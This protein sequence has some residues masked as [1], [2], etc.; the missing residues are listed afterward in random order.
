VATVSIL[1]LVALLPRIPHAFAQTT[2]ITDVSYPKTALYDIDTQR[3][4]PQLVLNATVTYADAKPGYYLAVGV[5]DLDDGNIVDGLG[6]SSPQPCSSTTEVAGC[7]VLCTNPQG[8]ERMQFSLNHPKR[9]WNLAL[10]AAILDD[11]HNPLPN[12]FSDYTFTITVQTALTLDVNVPDHVPVSV[13]GI[14]GSGSI[15][16]VLA[17][18]KH[19]LS[20]PKLVQ[21]NNVTRLTFSSWSDGSTDTNRSVELNH[22]I[23]LNADYITQYRLQVIT[24]VPVSGAGWYDE[25]SNVT[26][27]LQSTSAPLGGVLG[28][29]GAKWIFESWAE[30]DQTISNSTTLLVTMN[31]PRILRVAWRPDYRS[32]L[33]SSALITAVVV[34]I[35]YVVS[36]KSDTRK[37]R[38]Q[39]TSPRRKLRVRHAFFIPL[40]A[41]SIILSRS[42]AIWS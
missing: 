2:T 13:D 38:K 12:S 3:A 8:S 28:I 23:T 18:G 24:P 16:L 34:F 42:S 22:D 32:P 9:V 14:N 5:F 39:G 20:V 21:I 40:R 33:T 41:S 27:S 29:L 19:S 1:I 36:T 17:A 37:R 7:L 25:A 30:D 15:L 26:L 10:V 6:S 31:S 4:N 11:A 35:L